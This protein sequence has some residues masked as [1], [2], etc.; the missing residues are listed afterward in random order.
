M[1][2]KEKFMKIANDDNTSREDL[3]D[4]IAIALDL[5]DLEQAI[6]DYEIETTS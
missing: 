6:E 4:I 2:T 1:T 3:I 5:D